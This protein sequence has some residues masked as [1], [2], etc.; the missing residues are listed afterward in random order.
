MKSSSWN[1]SSVYE[2]V[3]ELLVLGTAL[4]GPLKVK[5]LFPIQ[6]YSSAVFTVSFYFEIRFTFWYYIYS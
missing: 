3:I 4:A 2:N 1:A 6:K 5:T